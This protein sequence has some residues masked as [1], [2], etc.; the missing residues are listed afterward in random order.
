MD[1]THRGPQSRD[2][3]DSGALA[4]TVQLVA[5]EYLLTVN[6]VDGSEIEICPPADL[7]APPERHTAEAREAFQRAA[8]PSPPVG[9]SARIT[10][11]LPLL[12][13]QD[14]RE[15]VVRLLSRGRSVRLVGRPGSGRTALL[16][17]VAE[18]CAGLAP[19]GVI[20]LGGHRRTPSDLLHELYAAVYHAPWH[21]LGRSELLAAVSG[22][23]AVVVLDDVAFGGA[24]LDELLRLTPECAFLVSAAPDIPAG[25]TE[26]TL[27]EV[28]LPGLSREASTGIL[29]HAVGR[30]L[31]QDESDWAA[32]L[33]FESEGLPLRFLQ[34][35]AVL[36]HRDALGAPDRP[37]EAQAASG[38]Y[39]EAQEPFP[40]V[41]LPA[42][43]VGLTPL[44]VAGTLSPLGRESLRYGVALDGEMPHQSHLPALV[45]D[46]QGDAA[47]AELTAAGLV[48]ATGSGYRLSG[49]LAGQL[50]DEGFTDAEADADRA[51]RAA[52]HYA[53]WAGH[54]SVTPDRVAA[55]APAVLAA[56]RGTRAGG[57]SSSA[58]LLAHTTAPVLAAALHWSAWEQALRG[59]QEAARLAGEVA[60]EA[61][62]HHELGVL[63]LCLGNVERA[64]SELEASIGLRGALADKRGA[65]AGRRALALVE[66]R[67]T[68]ALGT[69]SVAG[70]ALPP[71]FAGAREDSTA[72]TAVAAAVPFA[73]DPGEPGASD[74]T[75][76]GAAVPERE[77]RAPVLG[78]TKRNVAAVGAGAL[79]AVALGAMLTVGNVSGGEDPGDTV[80]PDTSSSQDADDVPVEGPEDDPTSRDPKPEPS[81]SDGSPSPSG[82]PSSDDPTSPTPSDDP[83]TPTD[84]PTTPSDEPSDPEPTDDPS[85]PTDE[86]SDP[87]PTD[88]PSEPTDEP[89]DPEPTD[90]PSESESL[91]GPSAP[92]GPSPS[93]SQPERTGPQAPPAGDGGLT[94]G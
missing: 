25:S 19:D 26:G 16:N 24:A 85:T 84:D 79:L 44:A 40:T 65:V 70:A 64:R 9:P 89:T 59:G 88:D 58:A 34:A 20:R 46:P 6:P 62:F 37:D 82:S 38:G 22:I 2:G 92:S 61:Y 13:R 63:A 77:R 29:E 12:E 87:E 30:P 3:R 10:E 73:G 94:I 7:P 41:E 14:E 57:H 21:R 43:T 28:V 17:A 80:K 50:A 52:Q 55:E 66:D 1:P 4:R 51:L 48:T 76:V 56:I 53:W 39:A 47:L 81:E 15:R 93:S 91:P 60:E 90:D 71:A 68:L 8:A 72:P 31:R 32:D 74:A 5:D 86:P 67:S 49:D 78:T 54:P 42:L 18:D 36:R 45:D 23:G 11:Q 33:W 35:G 69:P 75:V 27:T 83:T